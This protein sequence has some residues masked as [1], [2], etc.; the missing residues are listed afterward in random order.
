MNFKIKCIGIKIQLFWVSD[1]K[2]TKYYILYTELK[3]QGSLV[4][5]GKVEM[6]CRK[7]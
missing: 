3:W 4:D 1:N 2:N 7:Q 6:Q 5:Q